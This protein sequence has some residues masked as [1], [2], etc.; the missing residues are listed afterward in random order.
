[1]GDGQIREAAIGA[2]EVVK[3]AAT[4]EEIAAAIAEVD[5]LVDHQDRSGE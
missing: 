2:V 5:A 4:P 3:G 1:M